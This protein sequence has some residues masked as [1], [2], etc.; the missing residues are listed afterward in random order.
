MYDLSVCL[1]AIRKH[2]WER[3]YESII[4]SIGDYTFELILCGPH[5]ELPDELQGLS[6]V[7]CIQDFGSPVRAQQMSM[8]NVTG[9]YITWAADDGWFY[10]GGLEACINHLD[11]ISNDSNKDC[12]VTQYVEGGKDGLGSVAEGMYFVNNHLPIRSSYIPDHY[13]IFNSVIMHTSYFH[14]LGGFDSTFEACPMAF[15]DFGVRAQHDGALPI[16]FSAIFECT[17]SPGHEGDHGPIHDAQVI[18]DEN[19]FKLIWRKKTSKDR[20]KINFDNWKTSPPFWNRRF[21]RVDTGDIIDV[22]GHGEYKAPAS[23]KLTD[24]KEEQ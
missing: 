9:R 24:N 17:H 16:L 11:S 21:Q 3:L 1:A 5:E 15:V 23:L 18:S 2:N 10:E 6:N 20:I 14:E 19:K 7:S 4:A 12:V 13:L 22:T 8:E